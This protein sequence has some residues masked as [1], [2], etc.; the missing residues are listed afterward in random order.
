MNPT[1][2]RDEVL[3]VCPHC[4][5][6][7]VGLGMRADHLPDTPSSLLVTFCCG[8]CFAILSVSFAPVELVAK[9]NKS[10]VQ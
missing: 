6:K 1:I 5:A 9:L 10:A 3:P 8:A 2:K 7:G 4:K